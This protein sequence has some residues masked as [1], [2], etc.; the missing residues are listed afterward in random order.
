M[1]T[2][3]ASFLCFIKLVLNILWAW[4][5]STAVPWALLTGCWEVLCTHAPVGAY[6]LCPWAIYQSLLTQF[7]VH[8][9]CYP[10]YQFTW[11]LPI[12]LG[13]VLSPTCHSL[14]AARD[15]DFA[16]NIKLFFVRKTTT[17][18]SW[19]VTFKFDHIL[20]K[21]PLRK[22]ARWL[23][24][25]SCGAFPELLSL[26]LILCGVWFDYSELAWNDPRKMQNWIWIKVLPFSALIQIL[27]ES[28]KWMSLGFHVQI[29]F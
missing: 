1:H 4:W 8:Y 17:C 12:V 7:Q 5:S 9:F 24:V 3:F 22:F 25:K 29:H 11:G 19:E 20:S 10:L 27:R 28:L 18:S 6:N 26:F 15:F 2:I 21:C 23:C 13:T 14:A 16:T